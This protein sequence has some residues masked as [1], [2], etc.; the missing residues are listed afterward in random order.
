[1]WIDL[2]RPYSPSNTYYG[3][4]TATHLATGRQQIGRGCKSAHLQCGKLLQLQ[5][6]ILLKF[7]YQPIIFPKFKYQPIIFPKFKYQPIIFPK[8]KYQPII[9]PK[10]K[11]QP[12]ILPVPVIDDCPHPGV[13]ILNFILQRGTVGLQPSFV[14]HAH[15]F[16]GLPVPFFRARQ[17]DYYYHN[18]RS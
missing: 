10:F 2:G 18:L 13:K 4:G 17:L 11:Y 6:T 16:C 14:V 12:I 9:F 1:M 7:K 8:F 3:V 15:G 5:P